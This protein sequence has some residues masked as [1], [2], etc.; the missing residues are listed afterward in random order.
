MSPSQYDRQMDA[1]RNAEHVDRDIARLADALLDRLDELAAAMAQRVSAE[2]SFYVDSTIVPYDNLRKDCYAQLSAILPTLA[3]PLAPDTA[4]A[5]QSGRQR[6]A[7]GVPLPKIMDSYRVSGRFIWENLV[8]EAEQTGA[9]DSAA[10]VRAASKIWLILDS[11]TQA[12]ATA[13]RDVITERII[14]HEHE[15]SALVAALLEGRITD[16]QT[17]WESAEALGISRRGPYVVVA[18]ELAAVGR[19][20]LPEVD[21]RLRAQD[22]PSA[23]RLLPD[24]QVGIVVLPKKEGGLDRLVAVLNRRA[25]HP[26]GVS[27][28]YPT[29]DGT[30]TALRFAKIAMSG[31]RPTGPKVIV[32]DKSPLAVAAASAPEV[33]ARIVGSILGPLDQLPAGERSTLLD[34]L[35]AWRDSGG[36][37]EQ[38]AA[39][40]HCHSNTVRHRLRRITEATGRSFTA[41]QD[42][43]ELCLALE[44]ARQ[45]KI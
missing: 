14:A 16:N 42:I 19:Q 24:L 18:A 13:Y 43:A 4:Y 12:M 9:L 7:D 23:W 6:A 1:T 15:R 38:T 44:A 21:A 29:L 36:S 25:R 41:P 8:A 40:L 31:V 32:F 10:L 2:V 35:E 11:F 39:A 5:T 28:P 20:A 45:Q 30:R 33:M 3:G 34:T 27:P 17:L 37:T 26:V 22:L